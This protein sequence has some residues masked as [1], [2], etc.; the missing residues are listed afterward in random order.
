MSTT[1]VELKIY[2]EGRRRASPWRIDRIR[3]SA[4]RMTAMIRDRLR[5]NRSRRELA[6]LDAR[7]LRD[8][9]LTR[10]QAQ[11]EASFW[12]VRLRP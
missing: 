7:L 2:G 9:G 12:K 6:G 11:Y 10:A 8:I 3:T 4:L 1:C 5:R